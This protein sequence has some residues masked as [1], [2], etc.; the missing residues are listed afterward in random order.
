MNLAGKLDAFPVRSKPQ[1]PSAPFAEILSP[2]AR[3]YVCVYMPR[4]GG[5]HR[6]SIHRRFRGQMGE[7]WK[8]L[9]CKRAYGDCRAQCDSLALTL[10]SEGTREARA[11]HPRTTPLIGVASPRVTRFATRHCF[12]DDARNIPNSPGHSQRT[13]TVRPTFRFISRRARPIDVARLAERVR[14]ARS[15]ARKYA[16]TG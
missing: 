2:F 11:A 9:H 13:R 10:R 12:G 15:G 14:P 7:F 8:P 1:R 5:L 16:D 4:E 6:H 3:I